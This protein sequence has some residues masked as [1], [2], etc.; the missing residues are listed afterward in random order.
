M[1]CKHN[2]PSGWLRCDQQ[3]LVIDVCTVIGYYFYKW[4]SKDRCSV[5]QTRIL[6]PIDGAS[7]TSKQHGRREAGV[8]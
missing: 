4:A 1:H 3:K 5:A 6:F 7:A 8:I 2:F